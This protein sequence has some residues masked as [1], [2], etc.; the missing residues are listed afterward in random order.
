MAEQQTRNLM[1]DFNRNREA[2]KMDFK[3]QMAAVETWMRRA[4]RGSAGANTNTVKPPKFY[5]STSLDVLHCQFKAVANH[6]NWTPRQKSADLLSVLQGQAP[7]ILHS[8]PAKATY[9][10][11]VGALWDRF[12]VHQ[13][14][15]A[16]WS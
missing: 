8:M 5:G 6:N 3:M 4:S 16:Y 11:I 13:L 10:N 15:V 12:C 7:E 2:T 9:E 14:A 1:E